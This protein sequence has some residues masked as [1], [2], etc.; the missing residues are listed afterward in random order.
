MEIFALYPDRD[1]LIEK[2]PFKFINMDL[3]KMH[4]AYNMHCDILTRDS[5]D[6]GLLFPTASYFFEKRYAPIEHIVME[7]LIIGN[8]RYLGRPNEFAYRIIY[9]MPLNVFHPSL[10][11]F[12]IILAFIKKQ[13]TAEMISLD[14]EIIFD[15]NNINIYEHMLIYTNKFNAYSSYDIK[16]YIRQF[17]S[18]LK[19]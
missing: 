15:F 3:Y 13:Y 8:K 11:P 19:K 5:C 1:I 2:F 14:L 17:R 6:C 7:N 18:N 10:Y 16:Q 4:E 9:N 12:K